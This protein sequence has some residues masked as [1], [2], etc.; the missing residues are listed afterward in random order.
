MLRAFYAALNAQLA[1]EVRNPRRGAASVSQPQAKEGNNPPR[2]GV[3]FSTF[4]QAQGL[5]GSKS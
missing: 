2:F 4:A 1:I 5:R 3:V